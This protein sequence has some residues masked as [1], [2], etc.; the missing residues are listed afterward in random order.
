MNAHI[1]SSA[2]NWK[3][4]VFF[5]HIVVLVEKSELAALSLSEMKSDQC[6]SRN[7]AGLTRFMFSKITKQPSAANV[8]VRPSI[9]RVKAVNC[10]ISF[11]II[12]SNFV[13]WCAAYWFRCCI[14]MVQFS[15]ISIKLTRPK[16]KTTLVYFC[17]Y[18]FSIIYMKYIILSGFIPL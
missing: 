1:F 2:R 10:K 15:Q 12:I 3:E 8:W 11:L 18:Y 13:Y 16:L 6:S 4:G 17:L 7:Q 5:F 14:A 9:T